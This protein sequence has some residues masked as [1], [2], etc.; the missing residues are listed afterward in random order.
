MRQLERELHARREFRKTL[1]DAEL[2]I[3]RAI[4]MPQHD[5]RRNRR[6]TG[7]QRHDLALAVLGKRSRCATDKS[8]VAF[9]LRER[10]AALTLPAAGF[11]LHENLDRPRDLVRRTCR[12]EADCAVFGEPM[13]LAAQLLQFLVPQRLTQQFFRIARRIQAGT[14]IG[15]E[16]ARTQVLA[17]E[18]LG[19][20][21]HGRAAQRHVAQDQCAGAGLSRLKGQLA[22]GVDGR[23][24]IERRCAQRAV[25]MR[26]H[27]SGQG[28]LVSA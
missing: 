20:G 23:V 6:V 22:D 12:V 7:A 15:L 10:R 14:E 17:P 16:H 27:Q 25:G 3:E 13:A 4:L 11:K 18:A 8:G 1:I 5:G 24:A 21:L 28:N 26:A 9:I 2:E 19:E